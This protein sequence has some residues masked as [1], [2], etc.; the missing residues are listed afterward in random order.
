MVAWILEK[1]DSLLDFIVIAVMAGTARVILSEEQ[2]TFG[3]YIRMI[4]VAGF[5]GYVANT[6]LQDTDWGDGKKGLVVAVSSLLATDI[7]NALL[8]LGKRFARDPLK[9]LSDLRNFK[10]DL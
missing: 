2:R 10:K 9:T 4:I 3:A 6:Y 5:V 1:L 7:L 8:L